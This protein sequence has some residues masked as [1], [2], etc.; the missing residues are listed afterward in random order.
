[1]S[2]KDLTIKNGKKKCQRSST[3]SREKGTEKAFSGEY[4][5]ADEGTYVAPDAESILA[6]RRS[7]IGNGRP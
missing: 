1:M 2:K 3:Y 4:W 7:Q 6:P 5:D